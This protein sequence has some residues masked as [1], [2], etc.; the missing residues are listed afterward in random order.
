MLPVP[1]GAPGAG[2]YVTFLLQW[3][4]PHLVVTLLD[5][6]R[7]SQARATPHLVVTHYPDLAQSK[8]VVFARGEVPSHGARRAGP[9]AARPRSAVPG[10]HPR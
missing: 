6:F 10:E 7:R 2:G 1:K 4:L 5:E 3:Q 8:G 9:R